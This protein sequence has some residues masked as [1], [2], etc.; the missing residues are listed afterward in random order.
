MESWTTDLSPANVLGE[1]AHH[2]LCLL[3]PSSLSP[4]VQTTRNTLGSNP[5]HPCFF[6]VPTHPSEDSQR[7][8]LE[9]IHQVLVLLYIK[10]SMS[11][12]SAWRD[13]ASQEVA[14]THPCLSNPL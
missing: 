13:K 10:P 1:L 6:P 12:H 4:G 11:S 3:L 5:A 2:S 8:L 7:S 9:I 14:P